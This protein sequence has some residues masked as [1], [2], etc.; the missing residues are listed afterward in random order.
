MV[1]WKTSLVI[2]A[3]FWPI[4]FAVLMIIVYVS[5]MKGYYHGLILG[6]YPREAKFLYTLFTSP[7][8]HG[9]MS[10][11]G[12]N[13]FAF[14][15]LAFFLFFLYQKHGLKTFFILWLLSGFLVW[16]FARPVIHIGASGL[17]YAMQSFMLMAGV[18]KRRADMMAVAGLC[19]ILFGTGF[20]FGM[21]P[22]QSGVSWESHLLGF[23]SGIIC[24]FALKNW[25]PKSKK[26]KKHESS[27]DEYAIFE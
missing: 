25:G 20:Y 14:I 11:L 1:Q 12:G 4:F 23:I 10:H 27:E 13:L 18:I 8:S 15:P 26:R 3:L 7:L 5:E 24:A 6:I 9:D 19:V 22:L 2:K 16:I 21:L 17:I